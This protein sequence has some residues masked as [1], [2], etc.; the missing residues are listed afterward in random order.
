MTPLRLEEQERKW[1]HEPVVGASEMTAV[2]TELPEPEFPAA[3]A[4]HA[5]ATW[6]RLPASS[7]G[8]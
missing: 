6:A 2:G 4:T 1:W 3:A 5:A 8:R 7:L